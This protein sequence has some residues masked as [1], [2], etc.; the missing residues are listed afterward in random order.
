MLTEPTMEKLTSLRLGAM[1]EAWLAQ[2][3]DTE[4]AT[5]GFDDRFGLIV[6]AEWLARRNK[7]LANLMR[8][9]K[10]RITSACLEDIDCTGSRGLDKRFVRD[11]ATCR[12]VQ[13]HHNLV[14]SGKTGVGKTYLCC[15]AVNQACRNGY[16]ALYR[17]A[18]RLFDELT[19]ARADGSYHRLLARLARIDV[20]AI[21]DWALV[22]V[23]D[24]ERRDLLEIIE[25][26]HGNHSTILASQLPVERWHDQIGDPTIADAICDR[27]LH[28]AHRIVLQGPT[29]R[30]QN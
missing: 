16:R 27:L 6:D 23:G 30:K 8:E 19:L 7:R 10:V 24:A 14:I 26:R 11:L 13:E 15:A 2:C 12:W 28:N 22:A 25:D 4:M 18:P 20:L 5:L 29:R 17:R 21:D 1:A 3:K 9:A